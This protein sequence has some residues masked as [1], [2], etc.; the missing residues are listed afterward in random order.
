MASSLFAGLLSTTV[1]EIAG[2][3]NYDVVFEISGSA[4]G[5]LG[6]S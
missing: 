6:I 3:T 4:G 5:N 2:T 1:A